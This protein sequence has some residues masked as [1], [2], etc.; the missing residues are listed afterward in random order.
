MKPPPPEEPLMESQW[1][2]GSRRGLG[3][4]DS[5]AITPEG[6]S[7]T[8]PAPARPPVIIASESLGKKKNKENKSGSHEEEKE[9]F[10]HL[11]GAPLPVGWVRRG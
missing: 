9:G 7:S 1:T 8:P 10:H 11:D 5:P 4:G 6:P 3:A 2:P